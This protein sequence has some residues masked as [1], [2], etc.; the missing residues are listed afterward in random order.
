MNNL[1]RII[2]EIIPDKNLNEFYMEILSTGLAGIQLQYLFVATGK[3]G[4][5]KSF[6]NGLFEGYMNGDGHITK[7]N[8]YIFGT[9]SRRLANDLNDLCIMLGYFPSITF[10]KQKICVIKN[11]R[12]THET[13]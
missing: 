13:T 3:G 11:N 2:G 6:L 9:A 1:K 10:K 8:K 4:N 7:E 12:N 5:G